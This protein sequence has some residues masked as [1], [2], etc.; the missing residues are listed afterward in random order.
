MDMFRA[1]AK[2]K[3]RMHPHQRPRKVSNEQ[4]IFFA[5]RKTAGNLKQGASKNL[6]V[7]QGY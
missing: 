4:C 5:T 7:S 2:Q 3:S 1:K 6:P